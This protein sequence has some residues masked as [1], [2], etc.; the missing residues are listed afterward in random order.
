LRE[1]P[2]MAPLLHPLRVYWL[3]AETSSPG[4]LW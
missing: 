1:H 4:Y 3:Q 2:P